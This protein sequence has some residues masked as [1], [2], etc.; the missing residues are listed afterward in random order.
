MKSIF[1][2]LGSGVG[3]FGTLYGVSQSLEHFLSIDVLLWPSWIIYSIVVILIIVAMIISFLLFG[4][5]STGILPAD[6]PVGM[7]TGVIAGVIAGS[8]VGLVVYIAIK[9][10]L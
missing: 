10:S 4:A 9:R 7:I 5:G 3:T 6:P 8:I 2:V 1:Q